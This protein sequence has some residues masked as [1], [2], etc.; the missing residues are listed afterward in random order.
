ML[1][2]ALKTNA[3]TKISN[4]NFLLNDKA[5]ANF[6]NRIKSDN[7]GLRK[8]AIRYSAEFGVKEA[9]EPIISV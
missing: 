9:V 8:S 4:S 6:I 7:P 2:I 1:V 5:I 3:Q